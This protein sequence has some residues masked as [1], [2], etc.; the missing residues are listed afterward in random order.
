MAMSVAA[1]SSPKAG[2]KTLK[3]SKSS[4][5]LQKHGDK[6]TALAQQRINQMF[7]AKSAEAASKRLR[8][9]H[10]HSEEDDDDSDRGEGTS[11]D[12]AS[13]M[14]KLAS[15]GAAGHITIASL[16]KEPLVFVQA[17]HADEASQ[18]LPY[19]PLTAGH[20]SAAPQVNAFSVCHC[21]RR[22]TEAILHAFRRPPRLPKH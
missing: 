5:K 19:E 13:I 7:T 10:G 11:A 17:K 14:A 15:A 18:K 1:S 16:L 4:D 21:H 8:A 2:G 22:S 20:A 3:S 6:E 12:R 9:D